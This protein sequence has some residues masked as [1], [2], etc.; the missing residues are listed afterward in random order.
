MPRPKP[1]L[2]PIDLAL[3]KVVKARKRLATDQGM[4]ARRHAREDVLASVRAFR[5][6]LDRDFP[7][8]PKKRKP[9][10]K[11]TKIRD[12]FVALN[13][14]ALGGNYNR[15]LI[16]FAEAKTPI[17]VIRRATPSIPAGTYVPEWAAAICEEQRRCF[18]RRKKI[19]A[20]ARSS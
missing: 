7:I 6:I 13:K 14:V 15:W 19:A 10:R 3:A 9:R 20:S 17:Q 11:T 2:D 1:K 8:I 16:W 12:G 4:V 5:R 18:A